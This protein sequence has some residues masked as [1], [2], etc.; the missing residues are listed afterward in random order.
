MKRRFLSLSCILL[1]VIS[2]IS[3]VAIDSQASDELSVIDGSYL[4]HDDESVGY[5]TKI[6]RGEDLLTGYSKCVALGPEE[7]YVGGTTIAAQT[8]D[9]IGLSVNIERAQKGDDRWAGYTVWQKYSKNVDRV[10]SNKFLEVEGGYYY[11]VRCI[12]SANSDMSSSFT[13]GIYIEEK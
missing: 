11:R 9:N 8:V 6:T 5:D 4:T 12:H 2:I 1:L 13:N 7:L 3:V 10:S